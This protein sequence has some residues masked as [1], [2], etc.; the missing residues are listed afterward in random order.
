MKKI[1]KMV[2]TITLSVAMLTSMTAFAADENEATLISQEQIILTSTDTVTRCMESKEFTLSTYDDKGVM[3]YGLDVDDPEYRQAGMEYM[4]ELIGDLGY[5]VQTQG[6][7]GPGDSE[8]QNDEGTDGTAY[9]YA[10]KRN[11]PST[12]EN[13]FEGGQATSWTGSGN[14]DFIVLNQGIAIKGVFVSVSW[15]PAISV[16]GTSGSWQSQPVY[17]NIVG[18]TFTNLVVGA[19]AVSCEFSE[20][21]DVYKGK[22][23][24]RP[25]T[26]IKF[27]YF[28]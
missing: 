1:L 26:N 13:V 28:S 4:K 25:A 15:P 6:L 11:T 14:C 21:G 2:S 5:G 16:N 23:I 20:N 19:T 9:S 3:I 18:A 27:S 17:E 7:V 22:Q 24:F 10:W 12:W 8:Y